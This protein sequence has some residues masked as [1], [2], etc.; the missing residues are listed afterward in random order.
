MQARGLI[1]ELN[2]TKAI[3]AEIERG[4]GLRFSVLRHLGVLG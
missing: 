1:E 2:L 4:D 3:E